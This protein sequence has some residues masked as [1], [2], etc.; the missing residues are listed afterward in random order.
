M[1]R[2]GVLVS[3]A[4]INTISAEI[5]LDSHAP[6]S[7]ILDCNASTSAHGLLPKLSGVV[8]E[9]LRG[10]GTWGTGGSGAPTTAEYLVGVADGGL[11][12]ERVTTDTATV[13]WDHGTAGQA[14]ATVPDGSITY[15]KLQDI[16]ATAR[17]LGR[18]TAGAGDT[19]ELT[20]TQ[21]TPP[22]RC[23]HIGVEGSSARQWRWHYRLPPRRW[24]VGGPAGR[25][26]ARLGR[27]HGHARQPDR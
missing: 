11:S 2:I 22:P 14:K 27:H 25:R 5:P 12:T 20:G 10:D 23:L 19:E 13:A 24:H 8:G 21:A 18:I 9:V 4:E 16:S 1:S 15:A 3:D 17:L 26:L 6:A 7:D